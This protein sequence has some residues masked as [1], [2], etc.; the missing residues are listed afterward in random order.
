[1][2]VQLL[3][4]NLH[5]PTLINILS[6]FITC[7]FCWM[8][9]IIRLWMSKKYSK[10]FLCHHI[11]MPQIIWTF[12]NIND[13]LF[14]LLCISFQMYSCILLYVFYT[15]YCLKDAS[16]ILVF[17]PKAEN[18]FFLKDK[19]HLFSTRNSQQEMVV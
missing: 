14:I 2:L 5:M 1:M 9:Q 17:L 6:H 12:Y 16:W 19:M 4:F 7:T 15:V 10:S 11:H 3:V 18:N 8:V 13:C